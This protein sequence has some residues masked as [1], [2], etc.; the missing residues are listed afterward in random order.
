MNDELSRRTIAAV[1]WMPGMRDVVDGDRVLDV[2]TRGQALWV[3]WAVAGEA[4]R[5]EGHRWLPDLADPATLGCIE[6]RMLAA[7]PSAR[8]STSTD[9]WGEPFTLVEIVP[10]QGERW[11][12]FSGRGPHHRAEAL[13]AAI[14]VALR[15]GVSL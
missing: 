1:G 7:W 13:V 11:L 9:P 3:R 4:F 15:R 6:G 10:E 2:S 5:D 12:S 8:I 14:E